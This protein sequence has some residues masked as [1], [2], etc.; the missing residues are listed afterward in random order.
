[1]KVEFK[2]KKDQTKMQWCRM[3][4][5]RCREPSDANWKNAKLERQNGTLGSNKI[6]VEAP[7]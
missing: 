6:K 1:M 3:K 5:N 4:D 7:N 2:Q